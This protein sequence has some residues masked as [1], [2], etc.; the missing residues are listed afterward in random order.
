M[1]EKPVTTRELAERL[2]ITS[3]AL[4]RICDDLRAEFC[5]PAPL[6]NHRP[7]KWDRALIDDWFR[8]DYLAKARPTAATIANRELRLSQVA[9][10]RRG[11]R[12]TRDRA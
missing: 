10:F 12:R 7:F 5:L 4:E 8:R 11:R 3:D 9:L 2:G 6:I 1:R